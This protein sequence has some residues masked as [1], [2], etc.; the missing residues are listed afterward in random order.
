MTFSVYVNLNK[1]ESIF[2]LKIRYFDTELFTKLT[3]S[4][5]QNPKDFKSSFSLQWIFASIA[6]PNLTTKTSET[7]LSD[8]L[9]YIVARLKIKN[10]IY[11]SVEKKAHVLSCMYMLD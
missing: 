1:L 5:Y 11:L 10:T 9:L 2:S 8:T 6:R 7:W 4:T 3:L